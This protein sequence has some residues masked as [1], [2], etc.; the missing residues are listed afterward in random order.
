MNKNRFIIIINKIR[1]KIR[2][3]LKKRRLYKK[4]IKFLISP[5]MIM[6]IFN[7]SYNNR[8][9]KIKLSK[10]DIK[11][12]IKLE[13]RVIES[14]NLIAK[15]LAIIKSTLIFLKFNSTYFFF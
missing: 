14:I 15:K 13:M 2:E 9:C 11:K 7:N 5:F 4:W 8:R 3:A 1:K 12:I 10:K 6:K